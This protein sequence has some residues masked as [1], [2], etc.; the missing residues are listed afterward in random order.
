MTLVDY[1]VAN[2]RPQ[3]EW[4]F[5]VN[6]EPAEQ[7]QLGSREKIWNRCEQGHAWQTTA[8]VLQEETVCPY[9]TGRRVIPGETDLASTH[10]H[11]LQLWSEDNT[12]SPTSITAFSHKKALWRCAEGH[13]WQAYVF[14]VAVDG[15]GC[16][17]CAGKRAI[18]GETDL[19]TLYPALMEQWDWEQNKTDPSVML[20]SS[21]EKV[22]W[23]CEQGHSYAAAV[24]SRTREKGSGCP[25]CTGK[26]VLS[27]FNDLAALKPH[28]AQQW[29]PTLNGDLQP[30]AVSLGSNKRVWW[31]CGE[32]HVWQAAVYSR[33]RR[34]A[35]G[36]PVCAG[37]VKAKS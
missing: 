26:K 23:R 1:F 9:C 33:T 35:A 12:L 22:W 5:D 27:G 11:I 14:S 21:H 37:T 15:C 10:P 8:A 24:F 2:S 32:G 29:H 13:V 19:Q 6:T 25:Y 36:C 20:P 16:P 17:Y 4:F 3:R 7:S 34:K 18:P 28:L 31:Q 30:T